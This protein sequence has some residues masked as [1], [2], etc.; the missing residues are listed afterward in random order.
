[1]VIFS[2]EAMAPRALPVGWSW[3][4]CGHSGMRVRPSE[5]R[6][7]NAGGLGLGMVAI[8]SCRCAG[9]E[10]V[11]HEVEAQVSPQECT[12]GALNVLWVASELQRLLTMQVSSGIMPFFVGF[13]GTK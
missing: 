1:M 3:S 13:S 8:R 9:A 7:H 5:V 12:Y 4:H 11:N 10:T 6:V 2:R